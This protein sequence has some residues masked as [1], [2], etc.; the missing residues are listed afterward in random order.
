[1]FLLSS[2]KDWLISLYKTNQKSFTAKRAH[3]KYILLKGIFIEL[4]P[5]ITDRNS[6]TEVSDNIVYYTGGLPG[7]TWATCVHIEFSSTLFRYV[8]FG[9]NNQCTGCLKSMAAESGSSLQ[10]N[11]TA[12]NLTKLKSKGWP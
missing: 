10:E 6:S 1:M 3:M 12:H 5:W 2:Y 4:G 8:G 7:A 11:M 9:K